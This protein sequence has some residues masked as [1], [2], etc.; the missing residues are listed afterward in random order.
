MSSN[1][2]LLFVKEEQGSEFK[3]RKWVGVILGG[4]RNSI[5]MNS[6]FSTTKEVD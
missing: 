5:L 2:F 6:L 3:H 1:C 4:Y